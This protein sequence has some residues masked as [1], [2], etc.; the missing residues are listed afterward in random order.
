MAQLVRGCTMVLLSS[1]VTITITTTTT[2][3]IV[4]AL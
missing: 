2:S 3:T 4:I 1:M